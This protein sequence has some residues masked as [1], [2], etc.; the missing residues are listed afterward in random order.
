MS[1][2]QDQRFYGFNGFYLDSVERRLLGSDGEF[3]AL[4][5]RAFDVL[6]YLVQHPGEVIDKGSLMAAVWPNT[7]V[8]EN[9]L[10]QAVA[11]LRRAL[12]EVTGEHRFIITIPGRG[13]RFIPAVQTPAVLPGQVAPA[14]AH[15]TNNSATLPVITSDSVTQVNA[16]SIGSRTR[17]V[18]H[19]ASAVLIG[20]VVVVIGYM[21]WQR[22]P[23]A[24]VAEEKQA[25]AVTTTPPAAPE[26]S[27][28]VVPAPL[29]S[30]AVLPF[31][32]MSPD[33][34]QEYFADGVA[35][36]ILNQLSRIHDLF[37]VGRTS[38]FSFKGRNEDLRVIGEKLGVSHLLEGSVR[39]EG[40]QVR[41]SAQLVKAAD[42]Y[43]LWSQSYDRDLNDI[44][45]IQDDIAQSVA[46]ALEITLGVGELGHTPGMTRNVEAYDAYLAGR[47]T[48]SR[49]SREVLSQAIDYVEKAVALDPD[50]ALAW[51]LLA[52]AYLYASGLWMTEQAEEYT[53]KYAAAVARVMALIPDSPAALTTVAELQH[54]RHEWDAAER[55]FK[56]ALA[57]A[58]KNYGAILEY[59]VFLFNLGRMS[60]GIGYFQQTNRLE[61]LIAFS[62]LNLGFAYE[63]SGDLDAAQKHYELG[64][65]LAPGATTNVDLTLLGLAMAR[66]DQAL[67][68]V[69]TEKTKYDTTLPPENRSLG[70]TMSSLIDKP[71]QA[72]AALQRF[73]ADPAYNSN[74]LVL[75]T[76]GSWAAYFD[77]PPLALKA[78]QKASKA[79]IFYPIW[80]WRPL[81]KEMRRLPGFK[82]IVRDLGLMDYWRATGNWGEFCRPVGKDDFECQ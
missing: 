28:T 73:Y 49:P 59:G 69:L 14:A 25:Q 70:P 58:P 4:S 53:K 33:K 71:E 20:V 36:E 41:V 52:N 27:V 64:R 12:G 79:P 21:F 45:I 22:P 39:K 9:N 15:T 81:L 43:H 31:I 5:S 62:E 55:S 67:V 8:E 10:N 82:D 61:P 24:P 77:D 38:S 54:R 6:H 42:G 78:Y 26:K 44:F 66:R 74:P 1:S 17:P 18:W 34:D 68:K 47:S 51:N 72:R 46:D 60:E 2:L 3:I 65:K 16:I 29:Q 30:V 23:P 57:L 76:I 7:I 40:N 75:M 13:Y 35:E 11:A 50:F 37:V 63:L 56:K 80:L 48:W 19:V 32:N